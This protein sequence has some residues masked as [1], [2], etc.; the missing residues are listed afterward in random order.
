MTIVVRLEQSSD[1]QRI[2]ILTTQAFDGAEHS[3]GT[4]ADIVDRLRAAGALTVSLVAEKSGNIVGHAAFSPVTIDGSGGDWFGLGPVSVAPALQGQG[5]GQA[6]ISEGLNLLRSAG[7][8]G[9]VVLGDPAYY[10]RFGFAADGTLICRN[11]PPEYFQVLRFDDEV[12]SG[13][14]AYHPAFTG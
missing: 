10:G 3:D 12:T 13:C 8:A 11:V 1:G 7:A 9:C 5:I 2:R 14:V 4:E 6:L